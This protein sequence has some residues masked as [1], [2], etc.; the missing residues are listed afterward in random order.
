MKIIDKILFKIYPLGIIKNS[1]FF[2]GDWYKEKYNINTDPAKHYLYEGYLLDYNPSNKFS[3]K[4]YFINNPDLSNINPLLHY[5]VYGKYEGRH[6]FIPAQD[7]IKDFSIENVE[8]HFEQFYKTIDEKRIV[9][10]DIFDTLVNRPFI[11]ASDLFL[12]MENKYQK[13]GFYKERIEGEKKAREALKKEVN[14]DDIYEFISDEYK[15]LKN[16]EIE[17]EIRMCHR[18]D[19]I[20]PL[21]EYGRKNNKRVIATSD[22]YLPKD[23]LV[24]MLKKQGYEMDEVYVSCA[25]NKTKADG[26]LF[27]EVL[28]LEKLNRED[29]VH[30]GDNYISDFSNPMNLGI[31]AYQTVKSVDCFLANNKEF[32]S[33]LNKYDDLNSS[34]HIGLISEYINNHPE[35]DYDQKI[36]Y[37]F[38]G[39]LMFGYLRFVLNVAKKNDI[40]KLLFV[41]RDGYGLIDLYEKYFD[42]EIDYAYT[43]LTRASVIFALYPNEICNDLKKYLQIA[44]NTF[45]DIEVSDD[46]EKNIRVYE[47]NIN[48][49]KEYTFNRNNNLKNHLLSITDNKN[50]IGI[51]D[52]VSGN[53]TSYKAAKHYLKDKVKLGI[54]AGSFSDKRDNYKFY[55]DRVLGMKDNLGI[56]FSELLVS[57]IESPIIGVDDDLNPIYQYEA[58]E[59]RI[60]R[61]H[62]IMSG[63]YQYIEDYNKYFDG[64]YFIDF[65]RWLDLVN[66]YLLGCDE[67]DLDILSKI[68]DS[69]NPVSLKNDKSFSD[70]IRQYKE[71]GY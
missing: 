37:C 1:K 55:S 35:I 23:V 38:A 16:I 31:S 13:E 40:D 18:N 28:R 50:S 10:F 42:K 2:D 68:V 43:Y 34:I 15:E 49:L 27:D 9:S 22:M 36:G 45:E 6:S 25:F 56:K 57:S 59:N 12:Y 67:K 52:M 3:S 64:D 20:Y 53:F 62:N 21:Y 71:L 69:N 39:V 61:Y 54:F 5:E 48:R 26:V 70:L 24:K 41:A 14:I 8:Q 33:Y 19:M 47:N 66:S 32:I 60:N 63:V 58:D 4:D 51:V 65:D 30:F 46:E 44:K 29:M 7:N 17:E 11:N